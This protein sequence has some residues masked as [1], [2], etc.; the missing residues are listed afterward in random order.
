MS[1]TRLSETPISPPS[2]QAPDHH[3]MNRR[4]WIGALLTLPILALT[5]PYWS[6]TPGPPSWIWVDA[7]RWLQF[8]LATPVVWWVGW[9][10]VRSGF[11]SIATNRPNM[12]APVALGVGAAFLY[13]A[14]VMIAPGL[15][16]ISMRLEGNIHVYFQASA[17][18]IELV[19]L[20]QILEFRARRSTDSDLKALMALGPPKARLVALG[21]DRDI[22]IDQVEVGDSLRV[23]P[24]ANVPV[25]G[26]IIE[27]SSS[28][29]ETMITGEPSPIGKNLGD[30]VTG[31]TKNGTGEFVMR[32]ERVGHDTMLAQIVEMVAQAQR[33]QAP[34]QSLPDRISRIFVPFVLLA[35]LATFLVWMLFGP[36]PPIAFALVNAV[37]VL[38]VACPCALGLASP[39]S[40]LVAVG[41]ALREG[42]LV[43]NAKTFSR[44]ETISTLVLDKTGTL[45]EGH[46][47]LVDVMPLAGFEAR[48]ILWLVASLELASGHSF[49]AAIVQGAKDQGL[50]L[51]VVT[52]F[53]LV[54]SGGVCGH[55]AGRVV[56]IGKPGF[57]RSEK[58]A[59][60]DALETAACALQ[61][62]GKSV[63]FVAIDGQPAGIVGLE[64]PIKS[65]ALS[66]IGELHELGLKIVMLTGD[67]HR[68]AAAVA[69]RI[70]IDAV[71]SEIE[72]SEKVAIVKNL[73]S[74]GHHVAMA[75]DGVYDAAALSEANVGIA[76]GT[77]NDIGAQKADITLVNGDLGGIAKSIRLGRATM[78][79]IR[80][81]LFLAFIYNALGIPLAAGALYPWF[82]LHLSP[83]IAGAAMS[84]SS[85]SVIGN[86]LRLRRTEL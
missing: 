9:P 64:D 23:A 34:I 45:T 27:G 80:Q 13:S 66:A 47:R 38:V 5:M 49:A 57:L 73:R 8:A 75:G 14:A 7:S 44:L 46:P 26:R 76:M 65:T 50:T 35:S 83:A 32:A 70:G 18:I 2:P 53:R 41:R 61:D 48:E 30:L 19:L 6:Q 10:Y 21:G 79:N 28:V 29:N 15:F 39:M 86:S 72:P 82:G 59:G 69:K 55:V 37:A 36:D 3:E 24:G 4:F 16:P 25:D 12:F 71:E 81:N 85:L 43:K 52:D 22:D 60:L 62:Q 51:E 1:R 56:C 40:I 84:L 33:T 68:T 20:G 17:V 74:L 77:G 42:V 54:T 63:V 11:H 78:G 31:G 67:N 58:I